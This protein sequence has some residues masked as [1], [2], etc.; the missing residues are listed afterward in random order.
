MKN[1]LPNEWSELSKTSVTNNKE[2]MKNYHK[3]KIKGT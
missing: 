2:E 3:V 1:I